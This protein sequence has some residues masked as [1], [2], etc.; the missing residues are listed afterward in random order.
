MDYETIELTVGAVLVLLP[1]TAVSMA[2]RWCLNREQQRMP[3]FFFLAPVGSIIIAWLTCMVA[4]AVFPP[5]HDAYFAGGSGL[6]LRGVIIILGGMLGGF[7]GIV[8]S[9]VLCAGN[10]VRQ[11]LQHRRVS[12]GNA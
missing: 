1:V 5:P 12:P 2:G 11:Y 9:V 6:D 3:W 7:A 8:T 4:V 10:L